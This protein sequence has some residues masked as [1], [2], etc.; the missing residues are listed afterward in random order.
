VRVILHRRLY[1]GEAVWGRTKKRDKW[2]QT[3]PTRRPEAE[4]IRTTVPPIIT[5]AEWRAAHDRLD[6]VRERLQSIGA[7]VGPRR[8]RDMDSPFLRPLRRGVCC[9]SPRNRPLQS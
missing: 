2:G 6:G 4:W 8:P 9:G 7:A 3:N 1:L 5:E